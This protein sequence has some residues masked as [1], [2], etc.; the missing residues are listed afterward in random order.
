MCVALTT[1]P[2]SSVQDKFHLLLLSTANGLRMSRVIRLL[3]DVIACY[4]VTF[5]LIL[6]RVSRN[7]RLYRKWYRATGCPPLVGAIA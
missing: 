1:H 7:Q 3:R 5:N 6:I 2:T 4:G